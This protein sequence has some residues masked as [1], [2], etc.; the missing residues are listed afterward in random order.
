MMVVVL[1]VD[2]WLVGEEK[3]CHS[4]RIVVASADAEPQLV[5]VSRAC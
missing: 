5:L 4:T 3:S 2:G 1:Q